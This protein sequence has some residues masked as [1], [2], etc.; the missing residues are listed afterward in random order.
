RNFNTKYLIIAVRLSQVHSWGSYALQFHSF[1]LDLVSN[2]HSV[3][4][5][6]VEEASRIRI[7]LALAQLQSVSSPQALP[8]HL[9]Y[10]TS[11]FGGK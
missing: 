8:S 9:L 1:S 11:K 2:H 10:M 6:L 7:A 3:A 5:S 4:S